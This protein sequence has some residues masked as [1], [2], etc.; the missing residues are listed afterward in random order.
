MKRSFTHIA[1]SAAIG[2]CL[3]GAAEADAQAL[4]R[5]RALR[6][7][8]ADTAVP[9]GTT[10]HKIEV[11]GTSRDYLV[12]DGANGRPGAP[13]LVI[14]HGGGGS[15]STM[16]GRWADKAKREGIVVAFPNGVGRNG[17][18]GTWNAGGCCGYAMTSQSTDVQFVGALIDQVERTQR[19]DPKR[20]YVA[21]MSNGGMMTHRIAI[22]LGNRL[23]GAGVVAGAMFG[24]E[25]LARAPVPMFIMHGVKDEV[26][27]YGGGP[28]TLGFVAQSQSKPFE[29]VRYAVD[30]W[31][32][33]NGCGASPVASTS[34]DVTIERFADCKGA[35]LIFYSLASANH[36]WPGGG[37]AGSPLLERFRYDQISA[38]DVLWDFFGKHVRK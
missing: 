8:R 2:F 10:A 26:V 37:A 17:R 38:T 5:L 3:F 29:G 13:L 7:Q 4:A 31:R 14:L 35:D 28:S 16:V 23:A 33:A 20:I 15:A 24:D 25:P 36:T 22:A 21:G 27:P 32:Q 9:A 1:V 11:A 34:G 12:L 6:A 18:M 30:F 19:T